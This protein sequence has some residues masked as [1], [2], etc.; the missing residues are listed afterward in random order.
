MV[1]WNVVEKKTGTTYV[2]LETLV[3]PKGTW[4]V[5]APTAGGKHKLLRESQFINGYDYIVTG[6][7][8]KGGE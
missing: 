3:T 8:I 1:A 6:S 4:F 2:V 5:I 7:I